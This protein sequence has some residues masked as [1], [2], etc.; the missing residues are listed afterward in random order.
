MPWIKKV[1][2]YLMSLISLVIVIIGAIMLINMALKAWV[3]KKADNVAYYAPKVICNAP[4]N[5][6]GTKPNLAPE[7]ADPDYQA[8]EEAREK[9]SR[10]AQRQRDAAQALA[11]IVVATPVFLYHWKLAR[12]ET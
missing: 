11:M 1:Y 9:E 5:P 4:A 8:K 10:A 7:C 6:D 3:F 12:K 2:L